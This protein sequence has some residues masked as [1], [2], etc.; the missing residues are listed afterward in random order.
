M[1]LSDYRFGEIRVDGVLFRGDVLVTPDGPRPW[2][3]RQ[4]HTVRP[5]DLAPLLAEDPTLLVIGTGHDGLLTLS[6][7]AEAQIAERGV[8]HIALPTAEAV[9][10]W[11]HRAPTERA[12]AL[13]HLTC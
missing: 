8:A 1:V 11:N 6:P 3:G 5:A 4:G 2:E 9:E 12:C 10:I 13:L 7:E